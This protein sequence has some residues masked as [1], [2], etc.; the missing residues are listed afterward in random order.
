MGNSAY[1]HGFQ[2]NQRLHD[3]RMALLC[4][5][6]RHLSRF[7]AHIS[8]F[9]LGTVVFFAGMAINMHSDHVIRHLRKP[10]D[11]RHY[12]PRKGFYKY[13]TAAN[14]LG[15]FTE[16]TGFAILT[17]SAPGQCS[18]SGHSPTLLRERVLSTPAIQ[19]NSVPNSPR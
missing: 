9:I 4:G 13:V 7:L 1:G 18:P 17:W 14:Y 10:G 3:W 16:W 2:H 11:T 8:L 6:A 5:P 12:I 19:K 15:E